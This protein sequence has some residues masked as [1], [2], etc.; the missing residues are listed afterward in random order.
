MTTKQKIK[1]LMKQVRETQAQ[2]E[3]AKARGEW[4]RWMTLEGKASRL[5]D[6]ILNMA[7]ADH[8]DLNEV[9]T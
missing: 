3:K 8:L 5:A 4:G 6:R 1:D 9:L 7:R 2:Q